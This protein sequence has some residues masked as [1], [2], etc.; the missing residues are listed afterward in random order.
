MLPELPGSHCRSQGLEWR[1]PQHGQSPWNPPPPGQGTG[2]KRTNKGPDLEDLDSQQEE[3]RYR[4][5]LS[6]SDSENIANNYFRPKRAS[7]ILS[8][9]PMKTLGERP[10][11]LMPSSPSLSTLESHR[12]GQERLS[13]SGPVSS[14][15]S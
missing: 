12:L 2:Y 15:V 1:V 10:A 6:R 14:S 8:T 11:R 7:Q 9:D 5:M 3:D 4:L 13:L